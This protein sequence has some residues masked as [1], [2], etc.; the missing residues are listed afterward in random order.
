MVI[1]YFILEVPTYNNIWYDIWY[2]DYKAK[3]SIKLENLFLV[4]YF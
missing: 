2:D 4:A 3:V 1:Q